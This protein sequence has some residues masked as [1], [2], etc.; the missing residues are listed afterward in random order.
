MIS[1]AGAALEFSAQLPTRPERLWA[2]LTEGA[3]L[4]HWF[5][6]IAESVPERGGLLMMRWTGPNA[7]RQAFVGRWAQFEPHTRCAFE[8]GHDGY[9]AGD[10]G[11]VTYALASA[12]PGTTLRVTHT[13]PDAPEYVAIAD[14]YRAAWPRVLE[15][16][17]HYVR[18]LPEPELR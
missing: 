12:D 1:N 14:R 4:D 15:R 5:C 13:F 7:T 8:G 17:D 6:D 9:P 10:A 2:L 18:S 16:L 11:R 3:H